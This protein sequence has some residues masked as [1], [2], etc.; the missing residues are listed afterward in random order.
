MPNNPIEQKIWNAI[1]A[2]LVAAQV[3]GQLLDYVGAGSIFAGIRANIPS[4]AFPCILLEPDSVDE[5]NHSS[6]NR[7]LMTSRINITCAIEHMDTDKQITGD[8]TTRGIMDLAADIKNVLG[9]DPKLGI[10]GD[11]VLRIR[12]PS[13]R[14]FVENYPIREAVITAEVDATYALDAR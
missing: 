13:T 6:P 5:S 7:I 11:G 3:S 12:F 14:Y 2:K 1:K 9:A 8:A 4:G 10:A